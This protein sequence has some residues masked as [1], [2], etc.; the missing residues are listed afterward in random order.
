MLHSKKSAVIKGDHQY[1][2]LK[3][4]DIWEFITKKLQ[5]R[6]FRNFEDIFIHYSSTYINFFK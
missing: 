1:D 2:G 6:M 5:H 3:K 4:G